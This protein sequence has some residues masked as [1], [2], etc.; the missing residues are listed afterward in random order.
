MKMD[1]KNYGGFDD[2]EEDN[3]EGEEDEE[4][5]EED[6]DDFAKELNQYRKAKEGGHVRGGRGRLFD[7]DLTLLNQVITILFCSALIENR[8]HWLMC[9]IGLNQI[10]P[11]FLAFN[12]FSLFDHRNSRSYEGPERPWRN[13][14]R[15]EGKRQ[16]KRLSNWR[17]KDG[18]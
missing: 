3:Y 8:K 13:E 15:E 12:L 10:Q 5:G 9:A 16:R 18:R 17:R 7:L 1:K 4:M 11:S 6:Y 14:R 2:Y